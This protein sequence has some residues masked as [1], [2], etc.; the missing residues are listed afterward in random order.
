VL[1]DAYPWLAEGPHQPFRNHNYGELCP[2]DLNIARP[3]MLRE[4]MVI[5]NGVRRVVREIAGAAGNTVYVSNT[6]S[7]PFTAGS[8]ANSYAQAQTF[9]AP[10]A[11]LTKALSSSTPGD[12]IQVNGGT[13]VEPHNVIASVAN[14]TLQPYAGQTVTWRNSGGESYLFRV[15]PAGT[16]AILNAPAGTSLVMDAQGIQSQCLLTPSGAGNQVG[17]LSV[18]GNVSF[19]NFLTQGIYL[20]DVAN[21]QMSGNWSISSPSGVAWTN[22]ILINPTVTNGPTDSYTI[23]G[24]TITLSITAGRNNIR[25]IDGGTPSGATF[26]IETTTFNL[27]AAGTNLNACG[28]IVNSTALPRSKVTVSTCVFNLVANGTGNSIR[29]TDIRNYANLTMTANISTITQNAL[30]NTAV[31]LQCN[32]NG[33]ADLT[34]NTTIVVAGVAL[35]ATSAST[36]LYA[37]LPSLGTSPRTWVQG[38]VHTAPKGTGTS[39]VGIG[40]EIGDNTNG[41]G[42]FAPNGSAAL[43]NA[44]GG[45]VVTGNTVNGG[46]HGILLGKVSGAYCASNTL[47]NIHYG[48]VAKHTGTGVAGPCLITLNQISLLPVAN[49]GAALYAKA[50]NADQF[51]ANSITLDATCYGNQAFLVTY[52]SV[53]TLTI[54]TLPLF[55]TN[56]VYVTGV[57]SPNNLILVGGAGDAS[58]ALF[59]ANN[60]YSIPA[61]AANAF[62]YQQVAYATLAAWIAAKELTATQNDPQTR[63]AVAT[64]AIV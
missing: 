63:V 50:A 40:I 54:S 16:G 6:T 45:V 10:W 37:G 51:V 59:Q 13:Y 4:T 32:V 62:T 61:I 9:A 52:D 34:N 55:K 23:I 29:G 38:N 28:I 35:D 53:A 41:T 11:S 27:T 48:V 60:Y 46:D 20:F 24:G 8:D 30:S 56:S 31:C 7:G 26:D 3:E 12:T 49:N 21:F 36:G 33:T 14:L 44:L 18:T 47:K 39:D 5:V 19:V 15:D 1:T 22:G 57:T 64:R 17:A 42:A 2:H 25:A 43:N 58:T